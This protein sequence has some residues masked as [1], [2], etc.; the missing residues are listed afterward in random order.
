MAS[1]KLKHASGNSTILDSPAANPSSDVTLK[2]PSTTGSAGQVLSVA[3]ANHSSTN[4]ELEF[5]AAGGGKLVRQP[6]QSV[7]TDKSSYSTSSSTVSDSYFD[8]SGL[9]ITFTPNSGT[10]CLVSYTVAM[11]SEAGYY[12][13]ILLLRGST[14]IYKGDAEGSN[15]QSVSS[16]V[17]IA[18]TGQTATLAGQFLDT[19]GADG[20][21]AV[22]YK[23][24]AYTGTAGRTIRINRS[25]DN[26]D[27]RYQFNLP[28]QITVMEVE[29]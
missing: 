14:G 24:Q 15:R 2:L 23:L 9:S 13:G 12:G 28:S 18:E 10:K 29:A 5:V 6:I 16:A 22:T 25:H 1:V 21:T 3:S 20:S 27:L 4:A 26:S 8:I 17:R 11:G 7:K 19:H